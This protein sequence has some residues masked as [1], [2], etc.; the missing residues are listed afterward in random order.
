MAVPAARVSLA[1]MGL[2]KSLEG[3]RV[4]LVTTQHI[5]WRPPIAVTFGFTGI[6]RDEAADLVRNRFKTQ[7]PTLDKPKQCV[8][9]VRLKGDV[10]I[11]YGKGFSPVIYV[12]EGNAAGRLHT[13]AAWIA[14]LL[15]AVPNAEVEIRVAD[16][17][18]QNDPGSIGNAKRSLSVSGSTTMRCTKISLSGS[19]RF[20][21]VGI[22]GPF[23]R[24]TTTVSTSL[25]RL[26]GM[27]T[28]ASKAAFK[29]MQA[30][31]TELM[32]SADRPGPKPFDSGLSR[33][34]VTR[35]RH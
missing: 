4:A 3:E 28:S 32:S 8:Y 9:V 18:R 12:G 30:T 14:E 10:A 15:V 23:A 11:A 16:C 7:F 31:N 5:R 20:Q 24:R 17:V 2:L 27:S 21:E 13:H 25:T 22:S 19:A 33:P 35:S 6:T 29:G 1:T 34:V 26:A